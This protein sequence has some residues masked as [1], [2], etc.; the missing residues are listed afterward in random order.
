MWYVIVIA[1]LLLL[2]LPRRSSL[3]DLIAQRNV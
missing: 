2:A 1:K 3:I